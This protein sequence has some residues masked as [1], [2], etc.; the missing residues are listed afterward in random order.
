M[1]KN[2]WTNMK[3]QRLVLAV[4]MMIVVIFGLIIGKHAKLLATERDTL[5]STEELESMKKTVY[6]ER[7]S[8]YDVRG[9]LV[10][11]SA[12]L[13][14]LTMDC[15]VHVTDDGDIKKF[16]LDNIDEACIEL[17]LLFPEDTCAVIK[18]KI[19]SKVKEVA[20][21]VKAGGKKRH[22]PVRIVSRLVSL[23]EVKK[24]EEI[25]FFSEGSIR[26]GLVKEEQW[27]RYNMFG[28]QANRVIGEFRVS[29]SRAKYGL[30]LFYDSIL[31][32]EPGICVYDKMGKISVPV[33][34][35]EPVEGLD[36]VMT[37]DMDMQDICEEVLTG[38]MQ[39]TGATKGCVIL[40]ETAT[41][42]IRAMV[43]LNQDTAGNIV[44]A[45][46]HAMSLNDQPGS[47]FKTVCM[48]AA[49]EEGIIDT[50]E[51]FEIPGGASV[52]YSG[53]ERI[54]DSHHYYKGSMNA[55]EVLMN[56]SNIGMAKIVTKFG[57]DRSGWR[58]F[59]DAIARIGF[60]H[61]FP[62]EAKGAKNP[63]IY[64][65]DTYKGWSKPTMRSMS[66]GY[67]VITTPLYTLNFYNAIA[68]DGYF[69]NP[70][71]VKEFRR[72][73]DIVK[74]FN[75]VVRKKRMCS[76]KTLNIIKDMLYGVTHVESDGT[77]YA[78]MRKRDVNGNIMKDEEGKPV[79]FDAAGKTGTAQ[80]GRRSDG[81]FDFYQLSF[82]GYFPTDKPK[83]SAIIVLYGVHSMMTG[84][85]CVA[86]FRMIGEKVMTLDR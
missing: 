1:S 73:G 34:L 68:N 54:S 78:S 16:Y 6:G 83:Y 22:D 74:E 31:K 23:D 10:S 84:P 30:E 14:R 25:A 21:E 20:R 41:G 60:D 2:F 3:E 32:G 35:K 39:E 44:Q 66:R 49:L 47:T 70:H 65:P 46:N 62:Q 55:K 27:K 15:S 61:Q 45:E 7:G 33:Y 19:D 13:Y 26:S 5:P 85:G 52:I 76:L 43:N 77:A 40:M 64:T 57:N 50:T 79:I 42:E 36:I 56:S 81:S 28:G 75:P 67:E 72:G 71:L 17:S 82:V 9:A 29:E 37:L 12:P 38:R 48:M 69:V 63:I 4:A 80:V 51:R 86:G 24:I 59:S 53:T 18:K 11:A 58:R 8:I